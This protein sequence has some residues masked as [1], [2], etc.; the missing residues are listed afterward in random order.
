MSYDIAKLYN[1]CF[2]II[3]TKVIYKRNSELPNSRMIRTNSKGVVTGD[4]CVVGS[5]IFS[6]TI[7]LAF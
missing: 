6:V 1:L 3:I 4:S 2:E 5:S 7:F